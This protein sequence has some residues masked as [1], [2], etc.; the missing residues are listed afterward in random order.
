[1]RI[2]KDQ[3]AKPASR[4]V[5]FICRVN[6]LSLW[7]ES[8]RL[9]QASSLSKKRGEGTLIHGEF[10]QAFGTTDEQKGRKAKL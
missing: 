9:T 10:L 4:L 3:P 1:M 6:G 2:S 8:I 5:I 7:G